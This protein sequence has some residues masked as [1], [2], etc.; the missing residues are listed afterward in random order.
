MSNRRWIL[1]ITALIGF[2]SMLP[3]A[4]AEKHQPAPPS[5]TKPQGG[6]RDAG[7]DENTF[8]IRDNVNLV[9]L[10]VSV[11]DPKGGF[12]SDLKKD[13]FQ[14]LE[15]GKPQIISQ[16]ANADAP[17]TVGLVVDN[18][19]SMRAKRP[20]V[21][22]AGLAFAK[23][24]N[25]RDEFF[26]VNFNN[27]VVRGLGDYLPFTD[28]LQRLRAA[29]YYGSPIGQTALYD[30]VAFSL[31]HLELSRR[32]KRTLIVV[33]DG[34]DNASKTNLTE[35]MDLVQSSRATIYTV[36]LFGAEDPDRNP[37][38]LNKL[39]KASGGEF[40]RPQ[41]LGEVIPVFHKIAQDVR[42]RYTIGYVPEAVDSSKHS[43]RTIRVTASD[44]ERRKLIV[45][46]RTSYSTKSF[47]QLVARK[48]Q[49]NSGQRDE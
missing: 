41:N 1:L 10:D 6:A 42:H 29:L 36:G 39:A 37:N 16:F 47:A 46:T 43:V 32:D 2:F 24:S 13:N 30:A 28:N 44:E 11:R 48:S 12:V 9:L 38:V 45:R 22:M 25:P 31:R 34:G 14:V 26:V 3:L 4:G 18:S 49:G 8:T 7:A 20:E 40:F 17:V 5:Q 15:D 19:G 35:T 23:E 27:F 21:V 33:S